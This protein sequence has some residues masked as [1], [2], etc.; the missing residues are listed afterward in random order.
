MGLWTRISVIFHRYLGSYV[1]ST[2]RACQELPATTA[3]QPVGGG[4]VSHRAYAEELTTFWAEVH[5]VSC[6]PPNDSQ[7]RRYDYYDPESEPEGP[8]YGCEDQ[9][10]ED[11]G[12]DERDQCG[13]SVQEINFYV[14]R[15]TR[16]SFNLFR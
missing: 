12:G 8:V 4:Q 1:F 3:A 14:I 6:V 5:G 7:Q 15:I 2:L 16:V 11:G 13:A 9:C 10:G